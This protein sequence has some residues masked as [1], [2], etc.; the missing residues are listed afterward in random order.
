MFRKIFSF[1]KKELFKV[2]SYHL[3]NQSL[4]VLFCNTDLAWKVFAKEK[5]ELI[6]S[7]GAGVSV[8]IFIYEQYIYQKIY[9]Q[10]SGIYH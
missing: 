3:T 5:L 7:S 10:Y 4:K 9:R 8:P 1:A 2:S 6:V